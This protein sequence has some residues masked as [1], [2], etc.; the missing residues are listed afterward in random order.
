MNSLLIGEERTSVE[1]SPTSS[2]QVVGVRCRR[3]RR[4]GRRRRRRR[5]RRRSLSYSDFPPS[6]ESRRRRRRFV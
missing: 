1:R 2:G 6:V 5:R 4:R 3:R